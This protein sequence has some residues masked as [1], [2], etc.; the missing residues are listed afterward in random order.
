V[1]DS[2]MWAGQ[3]FNRLALLW[4]IEGGP[5]ER[6]FACSRNWMCFRRAPIHAFSLYRAI[7]IF[8]ENRRCCSGGYSRD[9]AH[10][11]TGKHAKLRN[12][13]SGI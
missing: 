12:G 7:L 4:T 9:L 11:L 8:D 2:H 10:R 3:H 13:D 1:T 6:I 5:W